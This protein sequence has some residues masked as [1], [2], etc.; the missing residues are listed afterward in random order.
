MEPELADLVDD[1][2]TSIDDIIKGKSY[3]KI[4]TSNAPIA[5][6]TTSS[7]NAFIPIAAGLSAAA[8]AGL[9]AK[10]YM[11][12]KNTNDNG[13]DDIYTDDWSDEDTIDVDYDD[14]SA[15]EGDLEEEYT[16]QDV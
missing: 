11:D 10:A 16:Y 13:E 3:T 14:A 6:P 8:A 2:A 5:R 15:Q 1:A 12:R 7:G 9:G 4:P